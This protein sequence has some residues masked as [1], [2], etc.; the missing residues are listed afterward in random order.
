MNDAS[1]ISPP[2]GS[3]RLPDYDDGW[4]L[5]DGSR[6]PFLSYVDDDAS[7]NWSEHLEVFHEESGR[8]HFLEVWTRDAVVARVGRLAPPSS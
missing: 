8:E 5:D 3:E 2:P 7:V 6:A 1:V 4:L